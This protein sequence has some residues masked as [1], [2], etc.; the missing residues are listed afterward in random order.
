MNVP[1]KRFFHD[2]SQNKSVIWTDPKRF[3]QV[4]I[5]F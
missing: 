2:E 1:R 4:C 3:L 5:E